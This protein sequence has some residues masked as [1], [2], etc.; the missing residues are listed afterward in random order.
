MSL[1]RF[2]NLV[3][4]SLQARG[5]SVI[6]GGQ[7]IDVFP[8]VEWG[9]SRRCRIV[10]G[11]VKHSSTDIVRRNPVDIDGVDEELFPA[12]L[13]VVVDG[14]RV[15]SKY[16]VSAL[17]GCLTQERDTELLF[18]VS[19]SELNRDPLPQGQRDLLSSTRECWY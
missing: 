6:N 9:H 18:R 3:R 16:W 17:S 4:G 10:V 19:R 2:T 8:D 14:G 7:R 5:Q 11:E 13:L 12:R 1:M 15:I